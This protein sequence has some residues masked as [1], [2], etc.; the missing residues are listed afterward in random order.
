M[1]VTHSTHP[2]GGALALLPVLGDP[3]LRA[4]GYR[5]IFVP[6]LAAIL[7]V[8]LSVLWSRATHRQYPVRW[9]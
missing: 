2:P 1:R 7:L 8:G 9:F 6:A 5:F 3:G 4:L